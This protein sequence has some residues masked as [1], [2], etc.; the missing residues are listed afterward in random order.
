MRIDIKKLIAVDPQTLKYIGI[1][2]LCVAITGGLL[3][4]LKS[5]SA[6]ITQ[7]AKDV[8]AKEQQAAGTRLPTQDQIRKNAEEERLFNSAI[9]GE[10]SIPLVFEEITR[11][12]SDHRVQMEIQS[13]EKTIPDAPEDPVEASARSLGV[14]RYLV[15]SVKFQAEYSDAAQFLGSISRLPHALALRSLELRRE[16]PLVS[17]T[18]RLH[19]YKRGA[20]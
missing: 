4:D 3:F 19:V 17:G 13:E 14:T 7:L 15:V 12:G 9:V 5:R 1:A 8:E 2:V 20:A 10:E 18:M 16:P 11:A 6:R